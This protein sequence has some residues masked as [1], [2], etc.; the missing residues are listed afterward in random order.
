MITEG[1]QIAEIIIQQLAG[2]L[3]RL[4]IMTGAYNLT[5]SDKERYFSFHFKMNPKMNYCKITL[6][7]M[8][9]YDVEFGKIST[10]NYEM[11]YTVKEQ[12]KNVYAENLKGLFERVTGLYLSL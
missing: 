5:Y 12:F 7:S 6:N 8:D 4:I 1:Q 2:H 10:R 11:K 3:N 9:L